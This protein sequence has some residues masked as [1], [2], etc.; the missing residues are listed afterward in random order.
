MCSH[1]GS[2]NGAELGRG[3]N[4]A[5]APPGRGDLKIFRGGAGR[6]EIW[7]E[8]K[9]REEILNQKIYKGNTL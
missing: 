2:A 1:Q 3:K 8:Q 6:L 7:A 5:R 4:G 9:R